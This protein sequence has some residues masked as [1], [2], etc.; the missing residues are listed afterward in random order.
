MLLA[1]ADPD[2]RLSLELFF[3]EQPGVQI[4]GT[5]SEGNGL[6]ALMHTTRS[7]LILADWDLPG[8]PLLAVI[9]EA[10]QMQPPI[11]TIIMVNSGE[12]F[13]PARDSGADA[14]VLKG[15]PPVHLLTVFKQLQRKI[16]SSQ[17]TGKYE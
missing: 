3:D 8:L 17:E 1:T 7:H 10:R 15:T 14:I 6:R 12:G 13:E 2:L 4:V 11:T 16:I 9:D 5:T